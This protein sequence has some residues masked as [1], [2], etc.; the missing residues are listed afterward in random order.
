MI[1]YY[2]DFLWKELQETKKPIK[3]ITIF[4]EKITAA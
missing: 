4:N 3:F 2:P 1:I